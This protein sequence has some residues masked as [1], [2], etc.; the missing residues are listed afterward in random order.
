MGK[1]VFFLTDHTL[2]T[3]VT[4]PLALHFLKEGW[5]VTYKMNIPRFIGFPGF[6]RRRY[7]THVA[8]INQSALRYVAATIQYHREWKEWENKI[9]FS[10]T[11]PKDGMVVGTTK[12]IPQ[13]SALARQRKDPVFSLGYQHLPVVMQVASPFP[14]EM[15][16][17]FCHSDV[18]LRG[19]GP[20]DLHQTLPLFG[21]ENHPFV[22]QHRF[23]EI[24]NQGKWIPCGFTYL[25]RAHEVRNV[26]LRAEGPKDLIS[27]NKLHR[28]YLTPWW[29][30]KYS[31]PSG[32]LKER[33][34]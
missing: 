11:L 7:P 19:A 31:N 25:D 17:Q 14:Q 24:L 2:H 21:D 3:K 26:I 20:K 5:Q 15:D 12:D 23:S 22:V 16:A 29:L 27:N 9:F 30:Q 1:K 34:L 4:I 32:S 13:L 6:L 33:E 28:H 10:W 8:I 18:I